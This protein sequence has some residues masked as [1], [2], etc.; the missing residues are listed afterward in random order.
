VLL[1]DEPF[2][3]V[4]ARTE[5]DLLAVID[6]WRL[7]GRT[8]IAVLHDIDLVR[9][10]FPQ[11]LLLARHAVAWGPTAEALRPEAL[12]QARLV[13]EAWADDAPPCQAAA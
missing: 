9:A 6:A 2:N 4:D 13:A 3:A 8:V 7:A 5:A 1:L 12:F 10:R 11:T